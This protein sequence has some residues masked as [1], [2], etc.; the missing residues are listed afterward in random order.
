MTKERISDFGEAS[1][2]RNEKDGDNIDD[3]IYEEIKD[4]LAS[5]VHSSF[6]GTLDHSLN[7]SRVSLSSLN[8]SRSSKPH[9]SPIPSHKPEF[10]YQRRFAIIATPPQPRHF[11]LSHIQ[12]FTPEVYDSLAIWLHKHC[13][14]YR[15]IACLGRGVTKE[16]A[17]GVPVIVVEVWGDVVELSKILGRDQQMVGKIPRE[18]QGVEFVGLI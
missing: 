13:V 5:D 3:G 2:L 17:E 12:Y 8:S 15:R 9:G 14:R 1:D 10:R 6:D 11:T 18:V 7:S 4:A 16:E